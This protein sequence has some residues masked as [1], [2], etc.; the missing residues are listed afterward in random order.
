MYL[1]V[2]HFQSKKSFGCHS[3]QE[4]K[5]VFFY[6]DSQNICKKM[7]TL[8]EVDFFFLILSQIME[9]Q[10]LLRLALQIFANFVVFS[11]YDFFCSTFWW[12]L[13]KSC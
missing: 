3:P 2:P 7:L 8:S 9:I 5:M 13:W 10:K 12:I 6:D 1:K 4:I 11:R